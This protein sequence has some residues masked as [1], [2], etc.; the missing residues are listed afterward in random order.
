MRITTERENR[1]KQIEAFLNEKIR[2]ILENDENNHECLRA[3]ELYLS[4]FNYGWP[5]F[6]KKEKAEDF[7]FKT[8]GLRVNEESLNG[9]RLFKKTLSEREMIALDNYYYVEDCKLKLEKTKTRIVAIEKKLNNSYGNLDKTIKLQDELL[10]LRKNCDK[11]QKVVDS[12]AEIEEKIKDNPN[13]MY[14]NFWALTQARIKAVKKVIKEN[15]KSDEVRYMIEDVLDRYKTEEEFT[16]LYKSGLYAIKKQVS[17]MQDV[18]SASDVVERLSNKQPKQAESF[19]EDGY[20]N[21]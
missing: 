19:N 9:R 2:P 13:Y 17:Q 11:Y 1:V 16:S 4:S 5:N 10:I 12:N 7:A 8:M 21:E 3:K 6:F 20:E 14:D 15:L 18:K